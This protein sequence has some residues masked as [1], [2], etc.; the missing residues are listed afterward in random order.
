[1][2]E[3]RETLAAGQTTVR[4]VGID[5]LR[6]LAICVVVVAHVWTD[7]ELLRRLA[8]IWHV[9]IF[10]FLSGYFSSR[11]RPW[12][13]V[14]TGRTRTL[15]IPYVAWLILITVAARALSW[16]DGTIPVAGWTSILWGGSTLGR[17]YSTFW[18]VS[19]LFVAAL[20]YRLI[21]PLPR[22]AIGAIAL[23]LYGVALLAP[24]AVSWLPLAA[25]IG[26]ACL[27]FVVAGAWFRALRARPPWVLA[28]ALAALTLGLVVAGLGWV[29]PLDLKQADFGTPVISLGLSLV[30]C[31]AL[32]VVADFAFAAPVVALSRA[33][34][35]AARAGLVVVLVHP[36]FLLTFHVGPAG[37]WSGAAIT[38]AGSWI[39]G[40]LIVLTPAA[41]LLAGV[42]RAALMDRARGRER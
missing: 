38:L 22:V 4:D 10:F 41:R 39:L 32:V 37:S 15:A 40:L 14:L 2:A 30:I 13:E 25:G 8:Y 9:P 27:V 33:T 26:A 24:A 20:V 28:V 36:L 7:N 31:A 3:D 16:I 5:V 34:T 35:L 6:I 11:V 18:F 42:P 21:V 12:R 23:T 17:P 19:A 1:M 29:R